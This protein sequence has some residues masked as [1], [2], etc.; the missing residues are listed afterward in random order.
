MPGRPLRGQGHT[1]PNPRANTASAPETC[2]VGTPQCGQVPEERGTAEQETKTMQSE[3]AA[4]R[5]WSADP[6]T[7]LPVVLGQRLSHQRLG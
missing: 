2:S 3:H 7:T 6:N 4:P 5:V 1:P